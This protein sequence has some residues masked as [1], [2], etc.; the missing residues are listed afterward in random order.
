MTPQ[1]AAHLRML[2]TLPVRTHVR[3]EQAYR[4]SVHFMTPIKTVVLKAAIRKLQEQGKTPREI[5]R[6]QGCTTQTVY[7]HLRKR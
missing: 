2:S 5:A 3:P 7:N 1:Q 6:I 4:S